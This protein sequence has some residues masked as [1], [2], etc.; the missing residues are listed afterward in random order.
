MNVNHN[1]YSIVNDITQALQWYLTLSV[2]ALIAVLWSLWQQEEIRIFLFMLLLS[3]DNGTYLDVHYAQRVKRY[4]FSL[5]S[6]VVCILLMF[7]LLTTQDVKVSTKGNNY[8]SVAQGYHD[9]L[10]TW[11]FLVR[12][13]LWQRNFSS[14]DNLKVCIS[15][16]YEVKKFS[17]L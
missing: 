15:F 16:V 11:G 10:C 1:Q 4:K 7:H 17:C 14:G 12:F 3:G 9:C 5:G 13:K 8:Y 2:I 6:F